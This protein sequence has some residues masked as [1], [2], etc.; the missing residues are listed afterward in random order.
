[1]QRVSLPNKSS[2]YHQILFV[3]IN[4]TID[5]LSNIR[6]SKWSANFRVSDQTTR[7]LSP[8]TRYLSPTSIFPNLIALTAFCEEHILRSFQL[9]SLLLLFLAANCGSAAGLKKMLW[10]SFIPLP[11]HI[12]KMAGTGI[13]KHGVRF[14]VLF[15]SFEPNL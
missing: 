3:K 6:S 13:R 8:H 2:S 4:L 15:K 10:K 14:W 12:V 9:F 5:L 11:I 1:M 7:M